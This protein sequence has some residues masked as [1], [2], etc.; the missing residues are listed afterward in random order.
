M[1]P[2][3]EYYIKNEKGEYSII[4]NGDKENTTITVDGIEFNV[5]NENIVKGDKLEEVTQK[6]CAKNIIRNE[7]EDSFGDGRQVTRY[8]RNNR[9]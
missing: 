9:L 8:I 3:K 4:G 6:E 5:K 2:I 1:E 7:V